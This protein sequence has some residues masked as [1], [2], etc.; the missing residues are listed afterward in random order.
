[1]SHLLGLI[2]T[3]VIAG[4]LFWLVIWLVDYIGLPEP[5]NKVVKVVVALVAVLYIIAMLTGAAPRLS[6]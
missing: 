5:F 2:I 1:M 4:L 3:L 6:L